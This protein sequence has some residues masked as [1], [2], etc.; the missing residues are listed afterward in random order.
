MTSAYTTA[1]RR[2]RRATNGRPGMTAALAVAIIVILVA[3]PRAQQPPSAFAA[4]SAPVAPPAGTEM[5]T[6]VDLLVGRSTVLNVG[7]PI[8]RVSL[9]V[10]DIADAM[11]TAP[12]QLL[13][14]GKQPGT[15]SLFVWDRAGAIKTYEVKVRRDLTPLV[16]HLKQLFPNEAITVMGSG[17]DVVISGTVSGK[18]VI[19]KA[20]EV[21]GGYVEKKENVVNLL[22]Q[23]EGVASNQV[24]LRVRFAEVSR[25]AVMELGA[26]FFTGPTGYKDWIARTTTQQ[27]SAPNYSDMSRTGDLDG[28]LTGAEGK[29]SLSDFLN[30]FI[31]NNKYN[32]GT[33]VRALQEKGL[34]Q[35][36]AEPNLI[37]TNGKEASFLAGGEYPYPV[38]QGGTNSSTS[39]TIMFK[40]FGV[41]L[42]FTPTV[43][44]GDLI[45][46]KVKPEVSSL[47]FGNAVTVS[48][49]RVPAL[50]TRRTETEVELRDGQ[51]FA[52]AGL[53]NNTV[54]DSMR[55][56][57]GIGDIPILGWLFK[58]RALQKGQ[59]E[60]VVMI[61]PTIVRRG[62]PGVSEGLP[63]LIEPYLGA[64]NKTLPNPEAYV[65]SPRYPVNTPSR[66]ADA[67]APA[68]QPAAPVVQPAAPAPQPAMPAPG[69]APMAAPAAPPV[70][71]N[72]AAPAPLESRPVTTAPAD[73]PEAPL[74]KDQI[75]ALERAREEERRAAAAAEK[76]RLEQ[77]KR[78]AEQQKSAAKAE[79]KR[80]AEQ[81]K[82]D[83]EQAKKDEEARRR[84][85][86][87]EKERAEREAAET[88]EREKQEAEA[89]RKAAAAAENEARRRAEEQ[90][91]REKALSD[92]ASRLKQA[93]A[94]YRS[95]VERASASGDASKTTT[96]TST[97]YAPRR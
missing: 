66:G 5:P 8:A 90:Q 36:L 83:A 72:A 93:E 85:E 27:F 28:N 73:A 2:L 69:P 38:V 18:Y 17:K 55:K 70:T 34:F 24:M 21:A 92:A 40:E 20:A 39:V 80:L 9:T 68:A 61:T 6:D 94:E 31:F 37:A 87:T 32:I 4:S 56:I 74:T 88:Q 64:P 16:G 78:T 29:Y 65:G 51:T 89:A 47:D 13:V 59:T 44:G 82:R 23:Q 35:S 26:N 81:K 57:P 67:P 42:N 48:G 43:L 50:S 79:E 7:S 62:Q 10:P 25:S 52:I 96:A 45:N 1:P 60:L 95:Q 41:R 19:E 15:I 49:F 54:Q 84:A 86:K 33:V 77:E 76:E 46:L 14:H 11:V 97:S 22:K 63:S 75:K 91:K 58:S 12:T 53:M 71:P 3:A 30:I